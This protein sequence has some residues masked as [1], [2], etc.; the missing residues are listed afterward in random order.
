MEVLGSAD[1][2]GAAA[3]TA[4]R[5]EDVVGILFLDDGGIVNALDVAV[6]CEEFRLAGVRGADDESGERAEARIFLTVI[7]STPSFTFSMV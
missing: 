6:E 2:N 3:R 4:A 7:S 1:R 5:T